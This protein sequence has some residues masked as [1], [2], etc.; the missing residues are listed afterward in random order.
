MK[1]K[2][3]SAHEVAEKARGRKADHNYILNGSFMDG[4]FK[5]FPGTDEIEFMAQLAIALK[6]HTRL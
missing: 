5:R 4:G 3:L 2:E 1:E 6:S